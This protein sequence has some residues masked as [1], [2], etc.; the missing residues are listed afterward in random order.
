[1]V[2]GF[3]AVLLQACQAGQVAGEGLAVSGVP[4]LAEWTAEQ[5][6]AAISSSSNGS[7]SSSSQMI[8]AMLREV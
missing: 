8:A 6:L 4:Q 3:Q 5:W 2:V 7:S 1:V